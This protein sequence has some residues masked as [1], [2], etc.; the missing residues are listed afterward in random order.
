MWFAGLDGVNVVDPRHLPFNKLPPPVH[1]EQ[2]TADRKP[3][4][5]TAENNGN[6]RLPALS[7]DLEIDYTALS[8]VAP[9]KIRFRYKLEGYDRDWQEAGNRRQAFYTNLPPRNYRFLV[10]ACNNNGVWNEAG[11]FLDFTIAPAYYQTAW[12]RIALAAVFLIVLLALYQ[13]RVRQ[14]ANKVQ[15]RVEE[16]HAERERIAR[17]L[18]DTFLQS[19]QG[20]ILKFHAGVMQI[21]EDQPAR[22]TMEK[23]LDSAD[24]VLAE[25]RERL[26]NLRV[27]AIPIGGLP[28]AFQRVAEET[29]QTE[30]TIFKTVVEGHVR[31]LHNSI[32]EEA[33]SIGREALV[34]AFTHANARHVEVE[35]IYD[36]R[37]FRLRVRDDGR[38]IEPAILEEGR[39]DHWGM[40]G[41]RERAERIGAELNIWSRP[42][43]G[44]EV[45]LTIPGTTAYVSHSRNRNGFL[46]SVRR[47]LGF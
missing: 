6:L 41:M 36:P 3:Y 44:T 45:E 13:I 16:R 35:I 17:E 23:A 43:T 22:A 31:E 30:N 12:F 20:L 4:D 42:D 37:Q 11:A 38:G 28:A 46:G 15:G 32:Q 25:G 40:R 18:H 24:E 5:L 19:V 8:F 26:R 33:H 21:P 9:E 14:V 27:P 47:K 34:N 29:P 1:I 10:M 2:I 7:R 39:P